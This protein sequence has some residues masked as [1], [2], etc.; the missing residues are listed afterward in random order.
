MMKT[1][2][3]NDLIDCIGVIYAETKIELLGPIKLS[4]VCYQNQ[5]RQ[6]HDWSYRYDLHQK[7]N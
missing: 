3:D 6:W 1:K 2:Q 4:V 5:T 7:Q